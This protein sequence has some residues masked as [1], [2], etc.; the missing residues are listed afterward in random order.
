MTLPTL[1]IDSRPH[2]QKMA[3]ME[4]N[5]KK[6]ERAGYISLDALDFRDRGTFD[7]LLAQEKIKRARFA[8][9][10]LAKELAFLVPEILQSPKAIF[11]GIRWD[12]D[13]DRTS[14]DSWLC[15]CGVPSRAFTINGADRAPYE[16][17]VYLVFVNA[18]RVVYHYR[19]DKCCPDNPW[20]PVGY[21]DIAK[22]RFR[23]RIY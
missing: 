7:V 10:Q 1:P 19:W 9:I 15:Y 17:K 3:A 21:D 11:E 23:K 5:P 18:D 12:N 2:S 14:V 4:T 22:P 13:E 6:K 20:M 8:G 16:N